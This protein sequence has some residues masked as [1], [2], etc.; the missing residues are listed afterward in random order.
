MDICHRRSCSRCHYESRIMINMIYIIVV[1]NTY[2][3][4]RISD[5]KYI[6][7]LLASP[8]LIYQS[9]RMHPYL[10]IEIQL[11]RLLNVTLSPRGCNL[12]FSPKNTCYSAAACCFSL[13]IVQLESRRCLLTRFDKLS[14]IYMQLTH[15]T[16][17]QTGY[18]LGPSP[19]DKNPCLIHVLNTH[20]MFVSIQE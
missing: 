12:S 5:Q 1:L 3:C 18:V 14:Y 4:H 11:V 16:P 20:V 2:R 15:W 6:V 10:W 7:F 17:W 13:V 9:T 19:I 8:L